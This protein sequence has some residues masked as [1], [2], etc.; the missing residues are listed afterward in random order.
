MIQRLPTRSPTLTAC[1]LTLLSGID[2]ANLKRALQL[3]HGALRHEQR[4]RPHVGFRADAAVLARA[5]RAVGI[6]KRGADADRPGLRVDFAVGREKR[7]AARSTRC[8]RRAPASA[9]CRLPTA[10]SRCRLL[11]RLATC[12]YSCSLKGKYALIGSICDTVVSSVEGPTRS[13]ICAVAMAATPSMSEVTFVKPTLSCAVSTAAV[14]DWTAACAARLACT[15]LSNWPCAMAR[16]SASG[17]SRCHVALGLA[18]LR[19]RLARAARAPAR[20][21][22]GPAARRSRTGPAPCEPTAPS[23]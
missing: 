10:L 21:R 4:V 1:V 14:A 9:G 8:R 6:G 20:A 11:M 12:R 7:A 5:K 3:A 22:T 13:P 23:S 15:S 17:R 16:C 19:L 18:E 2:D